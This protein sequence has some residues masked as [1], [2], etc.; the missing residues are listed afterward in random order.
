MWEHY[1]RTFVRMQILIALVT[2]AVYLF[3]GHIWSQAA[4]FFVV[5]QVCAVL[6]ARWA[7]RLT[8]MMRQ[9]ATR[10]PLE[11]RAAR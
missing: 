9:S 6:G 4:T 3:F 11:S 1:K 2:A 7:F 8:V 10:L 5:M